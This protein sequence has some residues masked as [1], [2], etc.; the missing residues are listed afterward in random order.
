[1]RLRALAALV[2]LLGVL[3]VSGCD[4][5]DARDSSGPAVS[6]TSADP[7]SDVESTVSAVEH[8]VDSDS[9][10]DG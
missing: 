10:V 9:A 3:V 6:G 8:E 4:A 5:P 1:V 7:L 2:A